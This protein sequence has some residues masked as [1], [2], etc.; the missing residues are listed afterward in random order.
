MA[1]YKYH[2]RAYAFS[3]TIVRPVQHKEIE[4]GLSELKEGAAGY[5]W[6]PP[7]PFR[8]ENI[9]SC[10]AFT[11][12]ATGSE[13]PPGTFNTLIT[14]SIEN[15][16]VLDMLTVDRISARLSSQYQIDDAGAFKYPWVIPLGSTLEGL[17]L[18]GAPYDLKLPPEYNRIAVTP[19]FQAWRKQER[20]KM[21]NAAAVQQQPVVTKAA[22]VPVPR[23]GTVTFAE[24]T[25]EP[26]STVNPAAP[27][28][29]QSQ[30]HK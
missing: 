5:V 26:H 28:Q 4:V 9:I 30:V 3:V 14:V 27:P 10:S 12:Q 13:G 11:T 22:V 2:A 21:A 7:T 29:Q 24:H 23:F 1:G 6:K 18:A 15:L 16:N 20:G 25:I 19:D 17:R 8:L